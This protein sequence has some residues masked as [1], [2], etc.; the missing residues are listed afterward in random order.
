MNIGDYKT[1]QLITFKLDKIIFSAYSIL[2]RNYIKVERK[3]Q[4][5]ILKFPYYINIIGLEWAIFE[6]SSS[7]KS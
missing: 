3:L 4:F 6:A 5:I 1:V 7:D 2:I